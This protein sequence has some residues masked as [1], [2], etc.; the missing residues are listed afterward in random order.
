VR[1]Y[2]SLQVDHGLTEAGLRK[3]QGLFSTTLGDFSSSIVEALDQ[4]DLLHP[5][6]PHVIEETAARFEENRPEFLSKYLLNEWI[7][8]KVGTIVRAY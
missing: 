8:K 5:D 4:R 6:V 1:Q 2:L 7:M 3:V